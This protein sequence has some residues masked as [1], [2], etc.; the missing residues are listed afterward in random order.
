LHLLLAEIFA[1]KK[2]YGTAILETKIYL[3]MMP[4]AKNAEEVRERLA[5]YEKLNNGG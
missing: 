2:D 4:N 5:Q 1:R 3:E